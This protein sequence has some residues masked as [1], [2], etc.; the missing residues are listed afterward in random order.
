MTNQVLV[1]AQEALAQCYVA[2]WMSRSLGENGYV[3]VAEFLFVYLI[4]SKHANWLSS[5]IK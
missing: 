3:Y 1:I 2:A 4:L 5:N